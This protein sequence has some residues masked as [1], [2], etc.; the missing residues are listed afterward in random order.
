MVKGEEEIIYFI[1]KH[2]GSLAIPITN[3]D[4]VKIYSPE[5]NIES[6]SCVVGCLLY[7]VLKK[8]MT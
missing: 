6:T 5:S 7:G 2:T 4:F 8:T 3:I 1:L